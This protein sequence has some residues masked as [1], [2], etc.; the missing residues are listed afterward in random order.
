MSE[1]ESP[2]R[3]RILQ[4]AVRLFNHQGYNATG[5]AD[6]QKAAK[7]K[8]GSLYFHFESKEALAMAVLE[9]FFN[10]IGCAL[11]DILSKPMASPLDSLFGSFGTICDQVVRDGYHG[12]CLLGN[13]GA[14]IAA[15]NE[16]ARRQLKVYFDKLVAT[17][18]MFLKAAEDKGHLRPGLNL[19]KEARHFISAFHGSLIEV[20]VYR[21]RRVYDD[22]MGAVRMHFEKGGHS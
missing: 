11:G 2:T 7:I 4:T 15:D 12:G 6:I 20:R 1:T 5:I 13:F 22:V 9:E 16:P 21:D 17:V 3:R 18:E 8:R 19:H 14:E 10:G